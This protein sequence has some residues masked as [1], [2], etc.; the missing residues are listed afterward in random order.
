[1][2]DPGDEGISDELTLEE[3]LQLAAVELYK[4]SLKNPK[5]VFEMSLETVARQFS[6]STIIR[7]NVLSFAAD[8][9][10][11]YRRH[12][13]YDVDRATMETLL[14]TYEYMHRLINGYDLM[15]RPMNED[16]RDVQPYDSK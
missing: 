4:D 1:M 15:T 3:K 9:Y 10:N 13:E 7:H 6:N 8:S 5:L 11:F 2:V 12:A 14:D 16:W